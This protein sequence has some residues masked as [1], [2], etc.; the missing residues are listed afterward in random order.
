[1]LELNII[2]EKRLKPFLFVVV[3]TSTTETLRTTIIHASTATDDSVATLETV[4]TTAQG[5]VSHIKLQVTNCKQI[6][7]LCKTYVC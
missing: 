6:V 3:P 5:T 4:E 7:H 1:M 2:A